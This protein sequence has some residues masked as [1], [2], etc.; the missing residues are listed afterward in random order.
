MSAIIFPVVF[1]IFVAA[2]LNGKLFLQRKYSYSEKAHIFIPLLL[3]SSVLLLTL[4]N[5]ELA[6]PSAFVL[7][8][9]VTV[10]GVYVGFSYLWSRTLDTEYIYGL[11]TVPTEYR[12]IVTVNPVA[13]TTKLCEILFQDVVVLVL[14]LSLNSLFENTFIALAIFTCIVF[15]VHVPAVKFFGKIF[16][17]YWLLLSTLLAPLAFYLSGFQYGLYYLFMLHAS[18]NL[19]L[20]IVIYILSKSKHK[21]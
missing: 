14:V 20:Y 9:L 10:I 4:Y 13:D 3:G 5:V 11:H 18:I 7:L 2:V 21:T 8:L 15:A 19:L 6:V 16:G 12:S 17:T 1:F